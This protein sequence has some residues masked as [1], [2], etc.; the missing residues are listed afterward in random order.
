M[1]T[2]CSYL[3]T[4]ETEY[5]EWQQV[6]MVVMTQFGCQNMDVLCHL[7]LSFVSE[8]STHGWYIF[9]MTFRSSVSFQTG[10]WR[11][12]ISSVLCTSILATNG[13]GIVIDIEK[14]Q[15]CVEMVFR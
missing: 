8:T 1:L 6:C 15:K 3:V 11:Q 5:E 12:S 2:L 13:K 4:A 10:S 14:I 9:H 7:R